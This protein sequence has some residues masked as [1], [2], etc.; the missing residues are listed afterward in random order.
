MMGSWR[1][2]DEWF[3][4]IRQ[5]EEDGPTLANRGDSAE[6]MIKRVTKKWEE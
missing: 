4:I 2:P 3:N 5:Y 6:A 1:V